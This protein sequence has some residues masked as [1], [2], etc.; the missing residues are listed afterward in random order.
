MKLRLALLAGVFALHGC[1]T[2]GPKTVRFVEYPY[3][4]VL[5][6]GSRYRFHAGPAAAAALTEAA[7]RWRAREVSLTSDNRGVEKDCLDSVVDALRRAGKRAI[8]AA[9][10]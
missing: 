4:T 3:C 10:S 1:A 9:A 5:A 2:G 8:F 7:T 6:D